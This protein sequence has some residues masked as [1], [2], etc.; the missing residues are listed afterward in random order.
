MNPFNISQFLSDVGSMLNRARYILELVSEIDEEGWLGMSSLTVDNDN[1]KWEL[2]H[3]GLYIYYEIPYEVDGRIEWEVEYKLFSMDDVQ[4]R[5]WVEKEVARYVSQYELKKQARRELLLKQ[6][7]ELDEGEKY[8]G[9]TLVVV[10][11]DNGLYEGSYYRHSPHNTIAVFT[12]ESGD[13]IRERMIDDIDWRL[14]C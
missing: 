3:Y 9:Y 8:R 5:V 13:I 12:G 14:E 4:I 11:L 7:V 10:K 2:L 6:L 1:L